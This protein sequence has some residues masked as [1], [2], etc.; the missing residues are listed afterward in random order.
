MNVSKLLVKWAEEA[1][2]S[3]SHM[4]TSPFCSRT[5][6]LPLVV[7]LSQQS[8]MVNGIADA[9]LSIIDLLST[10]DDRMYST[11]CGE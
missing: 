3:R 11:Y 9:Q 4:S 5:L 1:P 8:H 2:E 7:W 10:T 6:P